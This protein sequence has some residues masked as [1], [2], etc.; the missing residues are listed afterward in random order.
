MDSWTHDEWWESHP[1]STWS[2]H[3]YLDHVGF[4][5]S[6]WMVGIT[7]QLNIDIA[8]L[9]RSCL[10]HRISNKI[11]QEGEECNINFKW[12]RDEWWESHPNST[13]SLHVLQKNVILI[14]S[15]LVMN[16]RSHILTEHSHYMHVYLDHAWF[17]R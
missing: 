4:E 6:W 2:F 13:W 1:N 12:I 15:G 3:V 14:L 17:T 5:D 16:D 11:R 10:V 8:C 9:L 7:S